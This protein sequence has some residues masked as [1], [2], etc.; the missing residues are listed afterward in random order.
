[1]LR[2]ERLDHRH[3]TI[4]THGHYVMRGAPVHLEQRLRTDSRMG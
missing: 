4:F 1:M 2:S 3:R